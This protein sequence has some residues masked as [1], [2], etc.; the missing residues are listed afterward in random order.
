[1][2]TVRRRDFPRDVPLGAGSFIVMNI[3]YVLGRFA[4]ISIVDHDLDSLK[5]F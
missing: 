4:T 1:M 2:E 3:R 5:P